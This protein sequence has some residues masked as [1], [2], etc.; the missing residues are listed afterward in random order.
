M[1]AWLSFLVVF[2]CSWSLRDLVVEACTCVPIHPQDAFCNSDIERRGGEKKRGAT[3]RLVIR[4]LF[5]QSECSSMMN[6]AEV[7]RGL[8]STWMGDLLGILGAVGSSPDDFTVTVQ[9]CLAMADEPEELKGGASSAHDEPHLKNPLWR[10]EGHT[11]MGRALPKSSLVKPSHDDDFLQ[12]VPPARP[13]SQWR[14][15]CSDLKPRSFL[16]YV[17]ISF[18]LIFIDFPHVL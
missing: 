12:E 17:D 10:L 3:A 13:L 14:A 9:A 8:V 5:T 2:L 18:F 1:T 16:L 6:R 7:E 11:H 15:R 4:G